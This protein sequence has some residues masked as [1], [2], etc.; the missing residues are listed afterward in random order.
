MENL[1][2]VPIQM[3]SNNMHRMPPANLGQAWAY[4]E[5]G[6]SLCPPDPVRVSVCPCVRPSGRPLCRPMWPN[7]GHMEVPGG[8]SLRG[9]NAGGKVSACA[10]LSNPFKD[11]KKFNSGFFFFSSA[12]LQKTWVKNESL[13]LFLYNIWN[14]KHCLNKV[15][16]YDNNKN[17]GLYFYREF[18][19][20]TVQVIPQSHHRWSIETWSTVNWPQNDLNA[21]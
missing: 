21:I 6:T 10:I 11:F 7:S 8:R 13:R 3:N 14:N 2:F 9:G 18:L 17:N 19:E 15:Y 1:T 5:A 20:A 12:C 4:R 16:G